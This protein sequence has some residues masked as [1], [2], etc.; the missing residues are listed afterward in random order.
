MESIQSTIQETPIEEEFEPNRYRK[1]GLEPSPTKAT[2]G[3]V[4]KVSKMQ[5]QQ[6]PKNLVT[7]QNSYMGSNPD[8]N[9]GS[10][11]RTSVKEQYNQYTPNY[12][13][14]REGSS[15]AQDSKKAYAQGMSG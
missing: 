13:N 10:L 8:S 9:Q 11:E 4:S 6:K 2:G 3:K 12:K 15:L 1:G 14:Q 7:G 5:Q